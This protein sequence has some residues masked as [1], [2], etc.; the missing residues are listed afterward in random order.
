MKHQLFDSGTDDERPVPS[1]DIDSSD[2]EI[3]F[4]LDAMRVEYRDAWAAYIQ[5]FD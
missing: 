5:D 4:Y 1:I 2:E 3:E